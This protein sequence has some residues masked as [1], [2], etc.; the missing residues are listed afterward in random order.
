MAGEGNTCPVCGADDGYLNRDVYRRLKV[1][2]AEGALSD[3]EREC[4]N[5]LL[6]GLL[7]EADE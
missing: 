2:E 6:L 5:E 1:R 7:A 4:L 3:A